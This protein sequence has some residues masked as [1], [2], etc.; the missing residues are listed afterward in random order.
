MRRR[1]QRDAGGPGMTTAIALVALGLSVVSLG[2]QAW[3][4]KNNGPVVKIKVTN[5]ITDAVTGEPEHYVNL[6]AFNTGRAATS[7]TGWGIAMPDGGNVYVTRPLPISKSLPCRLEPHSKAAF[8]IEGDELRRVHHERN[9]PFDKMRPWVDLGS[10]KRIL[11][12][13]SVPLT[14]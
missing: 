1:D 7:I 5:A 2:W 6:E 4:W 11:S 14:D 3:T 10:G 8:F 9:I 12:K 13:K